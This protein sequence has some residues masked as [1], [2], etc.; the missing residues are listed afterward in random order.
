[1]NPSWSNVAFAFVPKLTNP[2]NSIPFQSQQ[3]NKE[4]RRAE[5]KPSSN[6]VRPDKIFRYSINTDDTMEDAEYHR[7]S[8]AYCAGL[9]AGESGDCQPS[10]C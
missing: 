10:L 6:Y 2:N 5:Y 7:G 3:K 4:K 1:M 9:S 8:V